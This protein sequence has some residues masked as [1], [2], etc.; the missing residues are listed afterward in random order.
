MKRLKRL[1]AKVSYLYT[2]EDSFGLHKIYRRKKILYIVSTTKE[3]E[4]IYKCD[5]RYL[6]TLSSK[7][8]G[9]ADEIKDKTDE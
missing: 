5:E 3:G 6:K 9:F 8:Y 1:P 7:L 2:T 4:L